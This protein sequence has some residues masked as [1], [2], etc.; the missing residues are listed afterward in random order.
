MQGEEVL[1]KVTDATALH[2]A[3]AQGTVTAL[4][5]NHFFKAW[6]SD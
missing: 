5:S 3:F 6:R 2:G 1:N 4:D